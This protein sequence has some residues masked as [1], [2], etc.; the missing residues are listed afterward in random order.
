MREELMTNEYYDKFSARKIC[1]VFE[2]KFELFEVPEI[3]LER[4]RGEVFLAI[5][6]KNRIIRI[7]HNRTM[8]F[9]KSNNYDHFR[10]YDNCDNP[11]KGK[12]I[13]AVRYEVDK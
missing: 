2:I 11:G 1:K 6:F 7:S 10:K 9:L 3:E 12:Y 13:W 4:I 8:N 5:H